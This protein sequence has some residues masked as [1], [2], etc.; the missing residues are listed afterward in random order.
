MELKVF[1]TFRT[2]VRTGSFT[3]AA[4]L[5][6]YTPSTITFHIAQLEKLTGV[7][8][9]EKSGRRM[10]LT[11]AGEELIPYVDEV[12]AAVKKVKSFQY[13]I[14][15]YQGT[16]TVG[17]PESLLCF[18]LP[19]LLKRLHAHAP[20]VDLRLRSLTSRD[21]VAALSDGQIDVGLAYTIQERDK[22][23]LA[24][25]IFEECP[26]HFYTSVGAAVWCPN[27]CE[28]EMEINEMSLITMPHPGEIRQLA[29][30]YLRQRGISF[31]NMIE[32]RSTQ[33]IINLAE[34]DMGIA[35]LPDHAVRERM[36]LGRLT[37][38]QSDPM[39]VTSYY[40]VHRN[41]WRSPAMNL[42]LEILG[43]E[44]GNQG[45]EELLHDEEDVDAADSR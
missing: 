10:I 30:D 37:A 25:R 39:T 45:G 44:S 29:D 11:K 31:T 3:K 27:F 18:R 38:A 7:P 12:L 22:E 4:R 17:A 23:N 32:L 41:K 28:R 5:L 6:S 19:P 43:E 36:A 33:T 40:G 26:V 16:L 8:I 24:F 14:A 34:N 20:R 2:I 21:V 42:F 13:G 1:T 9:F 35:L 15:A